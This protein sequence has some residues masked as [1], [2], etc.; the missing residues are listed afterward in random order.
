[1]GLPGGTRWAERAFDPP[2]PP[3]KAARAAGAVTA[4]GAELMLAL[5]GQT[6]PTGSL[7]S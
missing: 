5:A 6:A 2:P 7:R 3:R 4:T 1:M